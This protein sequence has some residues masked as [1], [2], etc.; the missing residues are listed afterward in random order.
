MSMGRG[1]ANQTPLARVTDKSGVSYEYEYDYEYDY[2]DLSGGDA[3][4][5]MPPDPMDAP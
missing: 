5:D 1:P 4:A 3:E 2:Q